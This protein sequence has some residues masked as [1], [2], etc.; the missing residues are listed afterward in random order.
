MTT[1]SMNLDEFETQAR[2]T[3]ALALERLQTANL[4]VATLE[5]QI[6]ETGSAVQHLSRQ[7]ENCLDQQ[8]QPSA[9]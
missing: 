2:A 6:L 1:Q 4:M 7:L 5:Q 8:R 3:L 9:D